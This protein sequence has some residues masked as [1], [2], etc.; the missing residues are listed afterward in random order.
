MDEGSSGLLFTG[1]RVWG[2]AKVQPSADACKLRVHVMEGEQIGTHAGQ[3]SHLGG[4]RW[5][6]SGHLGPGT[7][8]KLVAVGSALCRTRL[9]TSR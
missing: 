3:S 9:G 8:Q 5:S 2:Y 6:F 4:Q 7:P 1:D